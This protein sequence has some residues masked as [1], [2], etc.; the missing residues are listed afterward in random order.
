MNK[1]LKRIRGVLGT[2]LTWAAGWSV[3]GAINGVVTAVFSGGGPGLLSGL[4]F[5]V[6]WFAGVG[7]VGGAVFSVVLGIAEGRRRFD[8]MSLPRFA[9]WGALGGLL[10]FML[11]WSGGGSTLGLVVTAS[12][13]S[14]MCAG[15]AAGPLLGK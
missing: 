3:V 9:G 12:I 7:F 13:M 1:W 15:S 10:L 5:T 11:L 14:L 2:G 6:G 8:Q 4:L